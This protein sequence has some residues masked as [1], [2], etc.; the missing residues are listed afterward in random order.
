M[1][2]SEGENY[3]LWYFRDRTGREVD[4]IVTQSQTPR[5]AIEARSRQTEVSKHLIFLK[6]KYPELRAIQVHAKGR[7]EYVN[8]ERVEVLSWRTLL[9]HLA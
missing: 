3:D 6:R 2:D 1:Q 4:F 5:L 8:K 9:S 7:R